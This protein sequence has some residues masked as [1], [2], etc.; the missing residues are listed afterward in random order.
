MYNLC[1]KKGLVALLFVFILSATVKAQDPKWSNSPKYDDRILHYGF[2]IGIGTSGYKA[3][4]SQ[5]FL[6]DTISSVRPVF[7][8][9]FTLGFV[10]SLRMAEHFDLRLLPTVGFYER[11]VDYKFYNNTA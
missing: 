8:T 4:L 10:V 9:A 7:S 2:S 1:R 5:N 11:K 6:N 3:K